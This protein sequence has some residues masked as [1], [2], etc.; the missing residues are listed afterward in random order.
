MV[1]PTRPDVVVGMV[2]VVADT[3]VMTVDE[4][5]ERIAVPFP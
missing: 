2:V 4:S 1:C 3:L 5:F